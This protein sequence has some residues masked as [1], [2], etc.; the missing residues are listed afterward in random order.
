MEKLFPRSLKYCVNKLLEVQKFL[1]K[2]PS[3]KNHMSVL[4]E[5]FTSEDLYI[6]DRKMLKLLDDFQVGLI[7]L[8]KDIKDKFFN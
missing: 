6:K 1:P 7:N 5:N 3:I 4:L 8:D 2:S